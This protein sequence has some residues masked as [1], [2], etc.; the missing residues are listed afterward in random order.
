MELKQLYKKMALIYHPDKN[1]K[2]RA[3]AEAAFKNLQTAHDY[4]LLHIDDAK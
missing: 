2:D 4:I 3:T 1:P